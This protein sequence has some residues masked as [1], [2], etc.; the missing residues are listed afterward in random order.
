MCTLAFAIC[1]ERTNAEE[2][3]EEKTSRTMPSKTST[4]GRW[5][6]KSLLL[7]ASVH[8]ASGFGQPAHSA[9]GFGRPAEV[10]ALEQL[11]GWGRDTINDEPH[12]PS[13][14]WRTDAEN[15]LKRGN[16][17][18]DKFFLGVMVETG[19]K[20][21]AKIND[22]SS[23]PENEAGWKALEDDVRDFQ[24]WQE[25][26]RELYISG[27]FRPRRRA[28][29]RAPD[30]WK[31]AINDPVSKFLQAQREVKTAQILNVLDAAEL[32]GPKIKNHLQRMKLE[33]LWRSATLESAKRD[34]EKEKR[35]AGKEKRDA[36]KKGAFLAEFK[37]KIRE[38]QDPNRRND[39]FIDFPFR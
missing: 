15:Y 34:A 20:L 25:E 33:N 11:K 6:A 14:E 24:K 16:T 8:A 26:A 18:T 28:G 38:Y 23:F 36:G 31:G 3:E 39:R 37:A 13:E 30:A 19:H 7:A 22:E 27:V 35:D 29:I 10:R 12:D 5:L 9:R 2:K 17:M 21:L 1:G 32:S 4:N